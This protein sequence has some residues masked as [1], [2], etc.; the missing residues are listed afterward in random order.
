MFRMISRFPIFLNG[1]RHVTS[2]KMTNA[3]GN[4]DLKGQKN[5][6]SV[7]CLTCSWDNQKASQVG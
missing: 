4:P 7:K 6:T 3:K 5:C 1:S 2:A